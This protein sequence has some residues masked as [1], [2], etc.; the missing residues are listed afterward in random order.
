M[1]TKL[2]RIKRKSVRVRV[3]REALVATGGVVAHAAK[4]LHASKQIAWWNVR[5]LGL[6]GLARQLKAQRPVKEV[7]AKPAPQEP[8]AWMVAAQ[9]R[10]ER[11]REALLASGGDL[12]TAMRELE[13]PEATFKRWMRVNG[14][15]DFARDLRRRQHTRF[16]VMAA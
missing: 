3:L 7:K 15:I 12:Q 4:R 14:L 8:P 1:A 16:R 2:T 13:V 9:Q 11:L 10:R 5:Q 6:A